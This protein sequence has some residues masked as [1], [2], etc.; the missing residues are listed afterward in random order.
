LR[1]GILLTEASVTTALVISRHFPTNDQMAVQGTFQRLEA[2]IEALVRVADRIECLFLSPATS[3]D[4][5]AEVRAH[6]EFLRRRWSPKV[7]LTI[8]PVERPKPALTRWQDHVPGIFDFYSQQLVNAFNNESALLAVQTALRGAPDLIFA[9]RLKVMSVLMRMPRDIG[10]TPVFFDLD[11]I[12]H[13]VRARQLLRNPSWPMERLKLLQIPRLL[14]AETQAIRRSRLTFVCSEQDRRYLQRLGCSRHVEVVPNS[15]RFPTG[16]RVGAS[17]PIVLFVGIMSYLPNAVA[18]DALVRDIWPSVRAKVPNARLIIAGRRPELLR[19]YPAKDPSVTLAGFV[20]DLAELYSKAR[21]VCC[22]IVY[23]GGTRVKIIEAA[24]HAR[25]IVSTTLG[26]EGLEFENDRE[27]IVRDGVAPLADACVR[28]LQD[29]AVAER[30]GIAARERA[31][32]TYE[33]IAVVGHLE[34][35][36]TLGVGAKG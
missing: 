21:V 16:A 2:Q 26:A 19:C 18:A 32:A 29:P 22:P 33:R 30:L 12:E 3:Q 28:L 36:F 15:V 24:A 35:L 34:R 25:A 9:H 11:D 5:P 31:R 8:A 13:L 27:I 6:E 4:T 7:C 10:R 1:E 17:E 23:G 20:D 14:L